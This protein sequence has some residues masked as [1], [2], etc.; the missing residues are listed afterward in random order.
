MRQQIDDH[1]PIGVTTPKREIIDAD[2][3]GKRLRLI[4]LHFRQP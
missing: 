4:S 3:S 2:D 1:G